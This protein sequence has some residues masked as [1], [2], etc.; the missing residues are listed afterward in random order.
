M[1]QTVC[2]CCLARQRFFRGV[3]AALRTCSVLVRYQ[4]AERKWL[5]TLHIRIYLCICEHTLCIC[6]YAYMYDV[7]ICM[8]V[9]IYYIIGC[10]LYIHTYTHIVV[11]TYAYIYRCICMYICMCTSVCFVLHKSIPALP[12]TDTMYVHIIWK[13][14]NV[15]SLHVLYT[16]AYLKYRKHVCFV[17]VCVCLYV[18]MCV[19]VYG[20]SQSTFSIS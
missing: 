14:A 5:H 1:Q 8:S 2:Y 19:C 7:C 4:N 6:V 11:Y 20:K 12:T 13:H 9:Y 16:W 18:Y 17:R 15:S 3:H 10:T